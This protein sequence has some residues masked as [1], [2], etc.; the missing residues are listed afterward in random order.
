MT[1][2][3]PGIF[4]DTNSN[5]IE[6]VMKGKRFD[7]VVDGVGLYIS[8]VGYD[9]HFGLSVRPQSSNSIVVV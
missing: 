3:K 5:K 4:V 9:A 6:I 8:R 2:R 1:K 7:I